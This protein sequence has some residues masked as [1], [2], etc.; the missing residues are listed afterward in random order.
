VAA[1]LTFRPLAITVADTLAWFGSQPE[2]RR[3]NLR[4]GLSAGR[5]VEILKAWHERAVR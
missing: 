1:G 3:S 5:E 4:A 2:N